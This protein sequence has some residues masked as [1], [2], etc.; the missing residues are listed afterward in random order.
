ME[1]CSKGHLVNPKTPFNNEDVFQIF[2]Q[3]LDGVDYLHKLRIIH[4]DLKVIFFLNIVR[5]HSHS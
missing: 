2:H 4:R 5:K 1:Y 3:V